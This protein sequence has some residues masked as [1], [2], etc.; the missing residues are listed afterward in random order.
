VG[1]L[2]ADRQAAAMPIPAIRADFDQALMCIE[3]SIA[4]IAFNVAS[5]SMTWR[6]R[7]TRPRSG[8]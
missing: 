2:A 7:L 1:A 5:C 8:R 3:M 4:Q 6:M